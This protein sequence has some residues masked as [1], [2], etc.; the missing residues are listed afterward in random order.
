[1]TRSGIPYSPVPQDAV[2]YGL[3]R[4]GFRGW[5]MGM[6]VLWR[7]VFGQ[8]AATGCLRLWLC[9]M[10]SQE[11]GITRAAGAPWRMDGLIW[12]RYHPGLAD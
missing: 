4:D 5:G 11:C 6:N 12:M 10:R 8:P 9:L 2:T 7:N 1:M 3:A